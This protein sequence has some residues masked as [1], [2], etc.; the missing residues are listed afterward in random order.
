MQKSKLLTE[1]VS[2]NRPI[3]MKRE[4]MLLQT[5]AGSFFEISSGSHA[6]SIGHDHGKIIHDAIDNLE[7]CEYG[8]TGR[9]VAHG[10]QIDLANYICRELDEDSAK[11][12]FTSGGTEA[13][14]TAIRIAQFTQQ[15]RGKNS[16]TMIIGRRYSYHGMSLLTRNVASHPIHSQLQ[17]DLDLKWPKLPEPKCLNCPMGKNRKN[18]ELEC[19]QVLRSIINNTGLERI[20]AVIFEPISGSTGGALLPPEGY[21]Q[22]LSDI[23][24]KNGILLIADETVTAFGRAGKSFITKITKEVDIIVGG[25]TLGGGFVPINAVMVSAKLCSEFLRNSWKMPLR[26]TFSGSPIICAVAISVQKYINKMNLLKK[27]FQHTALIR[28]IFSDIILSAD[29][30][31]EI[32]GTGHLWGVEAKVEKG[33]GDM[34]VLKMKKEAEKRKVEFMGGFRQYCEFDSIHVMYTPIFDA[35][36][37]ELYRGAYEAIQLLLSGLE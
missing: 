20:A 30:K 5:S 32:H 26:L 19:V 12:F 4:G 2:D 7:E 31:I 28:E 25:K 9:K 14:E 17:D 34:H 35:T 10:L 16:A 23:C 15:Q 24:R 1:N 33:K 13:V 22:L 37:E 18:C 11:V 8:L 29:Y 21:I 6:T 27:V 3:A 36:D